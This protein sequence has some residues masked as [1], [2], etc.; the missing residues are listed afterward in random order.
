MGGPAETPNFEADL[1]TPET[2][3]GQ[4]KTAETSPAR[5]E[6][7]AK[8]P[9]QPA[10]PTVPDDIP[11]ADQPVIGMP[12]DIN[13]PVPAAPT[14]TAAEPDRIEKEWVDKVKNIV[15]KTREDPYLQKDQMSK[16]KAQY[17]QKRF[18]KTIKTDEAKA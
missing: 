16:V 15:A 9:S 3:Q 1:P 17:I 5:P 8:Q 4:E 10:L 18:N 11:V 2:D 7:A 14:A 13:T 12:Q 6:Q